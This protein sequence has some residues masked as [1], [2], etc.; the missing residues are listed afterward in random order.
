M[1]LK[2]K[3]DY[4]RSAPGKTYTVNRSS[5]LSSEHVEQLVRL[6]QAKML[7]NIVRVIILLIFLYYVFMFAIQMI[8]LKDTIRGEFV[9]SIITAVELNGDGTKVEKSP[10][11]PDIEITP[12]LTQ[13]TTLKLYRDVGNWQVIVGEVSAKKTILGRF[14]YS[15]S[16][17]RDYLNDDLQPSYVLPAT[18]MSDQPIINA[19]PD[20]S[21]FGQLEGISDGQTA[22]VSFSTNE[23]MSPDQLMDVLSRYELRT[24]GMPVYSG[25]LKS[26]T[27]SYTS[28]GSSYYVPHLTLRPLVSFDQDHRLG[29]QQL[30][31]S[32][33]DKGKMS[34][35]T[36]HFMA[37]LNWMTDQIKYHGAE[38]DRLRLSY[39]QDNGV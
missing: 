31:F 10:F 36:E 38:Q 4:D 12:F 7:A 5:G 26:F 33:E 17:D 8:F 1:L 22:E 21:F 6:T 24:M 2:K 23:L 39:L 16:Y 34:E 28:S 3:Q 13:K 14:S 11:T 18:I 35:H 32:A 29:M 30:Y 15:L 25:E 20:E 9:R 27:T 19:S 37:D